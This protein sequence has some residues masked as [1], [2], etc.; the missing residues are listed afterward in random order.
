MPAP[1]DAA[2][3]GSA[4]P[5]TSSPTTALNE[6]AG[7]GPSISWPVNRP[8][9]RGKWT[10]EVDHDLRQREQQQQQQ[11]Q[12]TAPTPGA[13]TAAQHQQQQQQQ[14]RK[15]PEPPAILAKELLP[16]APRSQSGIGSRAFFL[17]QALGLSIAATLYLALAA[18][19]ASWRAPFFI[20][21]LSVFHFLEYWTTAR[22]NT[23]AA[24]TRSFLFSNGKEYQIAHSTAL[25]EHVVT[26]LAFPGWQA[27][28]GCGG[29]TTAAG[30]AL[31]VLGQ[32]VRSMAMATAGTNFNHLVQSSKKSDHVLVKDGVYALLRHPSYFG[33]F[34]W[35][36]GTQLMLGNV[37]CLVA[38]AAVLWSFFSRRIKHE[39]IF[40]INFFGD[41]YREYRKATTVKIPFIP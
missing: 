36:L 20:G 16:G 29:A 13:G 22:Y 6:P 39:E 32:T 7:P 1:S 37:V 30:V 34:W 31:I 41:E 38:Y 28:V 33:F 23:P 21:T 12:R 2:A 15:T 40:L 17:G 26:H 9:S 24:S 19:S 18:G 5:T 35:G 4:A 8:T 11:Q 14:K 10:P 27:R 3:N 25:L